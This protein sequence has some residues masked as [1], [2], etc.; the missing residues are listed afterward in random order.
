MEVLQKMQ[1]KKLQ[2]KHYK[3]QIILNIKGEKHS[4]VW[5]IQNKFNTVL[6][7]KYNRYTLSPYMAMSE[8]REHIEKLKGVRHGSIS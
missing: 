1:Y 6:H 7:Y 8:M 4:F 3:V 2:K 5:K